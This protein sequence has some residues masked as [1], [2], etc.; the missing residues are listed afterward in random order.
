MAE[1]ASRQL[2]PRSAL[3]RTHVP[4]GLLVTSYTTRLTPLTSLVM[5]ELIRRSTSG[6][7]T[8]LSVCDKRKGERE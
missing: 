8:N 1:L 4:G 2:C 5:R 6:G 3:S 7:K